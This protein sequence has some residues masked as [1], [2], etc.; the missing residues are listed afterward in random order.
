GSYPALDPALGYAFL[1]QLKPMFYYDVEHYTL[2]EVLPAVTFGEMY[3]HDRGE[4]K[5]EEVTRD[6]SLTMKYGITSDLIFDGTYNPDFSQ[7]EA[8]AGQV[9]VNLRYSLFYPEKRPFFLEGRENFWIAATQSSEIDPVGYILNT[10]TI[11]NPLVG[12]K[13]SGKLGNDNTLSVIYA[14]DELLDNSNGENYVHVPF[15][16]YKQA[17]SGDGFI[18]GV[19]ASR[20][21]KNSANRVGGLDAFIRITDSSTLELHGVMTQT[22][23]DSIKFNETGHSLGLKYSG[24]SRDFDYEFT[25][26]DIAKDFQV[27]MGYVQRNGVSLG[28]I[29]LRPKIYPSW[30]FIQRIDAEVFIAHT[31]D[32][33]FDMWETFNHVSLYAIM[34]GRYQIKVKYSYSTEIFLGERFKT[35]GFHVQ[36][37]GQFRN[38]LYASVLW[39]N[40]DAIYY[41]NDPFQGHSNRFSANLIY[42]PSDQ[43]HAEANFIFNDFYRKSDDEKIYDYPLARIKLTYQ[44]NKYL[45][46]RGIVEYNEYKK[47]LLTDF[48]ASFTYIPGTVIHLGY[49]SMYEKLEWQQDQYVGGRNFMETKR[50]FFFKASYLWRL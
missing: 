11:V 45:F 40:I 41:D 32:K 9:D 4:M 20:E 47:Q 23:I 12:A 15:I 50:G 38:N 26:R 8:D 29:L 10:R 3:I 14:L 28:T 16:R 6:L 1:T 5:T 31:R 13:F 30:E 27:D 46:F 49:G 44:M 36:V 33:F 39:R 7:I 37:T 21:F 42:E 43:F 25:L 35:G 24:G 34:G 19:A 17:L 2:L 18:G 48:L 22:K